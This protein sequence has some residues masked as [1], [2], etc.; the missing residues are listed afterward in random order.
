[1][2]A[3]A[4]ATA[5]APLSAA[6]QDEILKARLATDEKYLRRI[7]KRVTALI[8]TDNEDQH[9]I[10]EYHAEAQRLHGMRNEQLET[11]ARLKQDL[12]HAQK[13]RR[14]R[15]EYD[16]IARKIIVY[17]R[18]EEMQASL[19]LVQNQVDAL[20][21]DNEAYARVS[22]DTRQALKSVVEQLHTL[23]HTIQATTGNSEE[24]A[25][26]AEVAEKSTWNPQAASFQPTK[27]AA[28]HQLEA[29]EAPKE[30]KPDLKRHRPTT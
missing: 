28:S 8:Q 20:Q 24:T 26:P 12:E 1:M 22:N 29:T 7:A 30:G 17:P 19:A 27:R 10:Q 21:N 9:E 25:E 23:T 15:L 18:R 11:I 2:S 5:A 13:T 14:E 6:E 16:E 4:N 3:T